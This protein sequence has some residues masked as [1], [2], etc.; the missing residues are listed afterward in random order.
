VRLVRVD[1][2]FNYYAGL[3]ARSDAA[4]TARPRLSLAR[5]LVVLLS[6]LAALRDLFVVPGLVV[7]ALAQPG[8]RWDACIGF[9]P[10]GAL[11]GW[12]L[13]RLGRIRVLVYEDRDYEPGLLPDA[14]R[15]GYTEA[16]D[17]FVVP[18]ADL[19]F[20]VG[21][22]LAALRRRQGARAVHVAP[23]GVAWDRFAPARAATPDRRTLLFTGPL[24]PRCGLDAELRALPALVAAFPEVRL[25]VVGDGP[26]GERARLEALA[27]EQG[28]GAR[29]E[30]LG[31]RPH[32][33]L[34][35]LMAGAA[36]G[37]AASEPVPFRSYA[38]PLKVIEYMAAGLP[39]IGTR[40]TET[41]SLLARYECGLAVP[42]APE[43]IGAAAAR[44][45]GEPA[46]HERLRA[47]GLRHGETLS[48]ERVIGEELAR[49]AQ[50][51]AARP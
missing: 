20:S 51:R 44:L 7:A 27:R 4:A 18:R 22:R 1:P 11:V 49:I 21:E 33:D 5:A 38:C 6:P 16:V 41:E 39:V 40:D 15:R 31:A 12:W 26:A 23:N 37:L 19:V 17:R 14:F 50:A 46:L 47:N 35:G 36:V 25:R 9:G 45:L 43:A 10:W 29:V 24:L 30:W 13:R 48:W 32:A 34:P 2:F 42:F 8:G 3:R 28:V